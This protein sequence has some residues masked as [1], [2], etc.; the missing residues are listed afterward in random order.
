[1]IYKYKGWLSE[2]SKEADLRSAVRKHA[3]VRTL[4][5]PFSVRSIFS[6]FLLKKN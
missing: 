2:R 4:H 3:Q 5:H 1:M 6:Y